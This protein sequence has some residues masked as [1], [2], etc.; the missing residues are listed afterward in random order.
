MYKNGNSNKVLSY[1]FT[2][3]FLC[4]VI[5]IVD[6]SSP[7]AEVRREPPHCRGVGSPVASQMALTNGHRLVAKVVHKLWHQFELH[8]QAIWCSSVYDM[9]L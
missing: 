1:N 5:V 6:S 3:H 8:G 7:V 4:G 2:V 9:A